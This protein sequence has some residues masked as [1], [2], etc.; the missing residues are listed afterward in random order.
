MNI[1]EK[2]LLKLNEK[3]RV[4]ES[5]KSLGHLQ[6]SSTIAAVTS[7]R[8]K[9]C[10]DEVVWSRC[11][12]SRS[13]GRFRATQFYASHPMNYTMAHNEKPHTYYQ[14]YISFSIFK[15]ILRICSIS[16]RWISPF[17]RLE[18]V[19]LALFQTGILFSTNFV[20]IILG[21]FTHRKE[22]KILRLFFKFHNHKFV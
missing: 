11:P 21:T 6:Q 7:K 5:G 12:R 10:F 13:L 4:S 14:E 15:L 22:W 17:F 18:T 2:F 8:V 1:V 16:K 9:K 3:W 20:E 19:N